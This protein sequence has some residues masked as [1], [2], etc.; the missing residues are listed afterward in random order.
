[1]Q[2]KHINNS[3]FPFA[4][5][6]F[7]NTLKSIISEILKIAIIFPHISYTLLLVSITQKS[8]Y[9]SC[10]LYTRIIRI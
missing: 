2:S 10:T 7:Y 5:Y 3:Q 8:A 4:A 6:H 1:M 9:L